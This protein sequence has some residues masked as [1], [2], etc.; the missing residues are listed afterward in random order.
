MLSARVWPGRSVTPMV[1]ATA[2]STNPSRTGTRSTNAPPSGNDGPTAS[3]TTAASRVLPIPP[4]PSSV[5]SRV[6]ASRPMTRSR[7]RDRPTNVVREVGSP[8]R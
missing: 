4:G 5:T 8:A 3:A 6:S 7:S 1:A 2:R